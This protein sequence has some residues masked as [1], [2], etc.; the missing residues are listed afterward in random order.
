[1]QRSF[2]KLPNRA[3]RCENS[4]EKA[5]TFSSKLL[6]EVEHNDKDSNRV[7]SSSQL[8]VLN[9]SDFNEP[10]L[11]IAR[12]SRLALP[13]RLSLLCFPAL[14]TCCPPTFNS[15]AFQALFHMYG[16]GDFLTLKLNLYIEN[17][18]LAAR[19]GRVLNYS[20]CRGT[21]NYLLLLTR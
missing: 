4:G 12:V 8:E 10:R 20:S 7:I 21:C 13:T 2:K 1:M 15:D 3:R 11:L 5:G 6:V 16:F 18:G 17:C 9:G 14:P 19:V